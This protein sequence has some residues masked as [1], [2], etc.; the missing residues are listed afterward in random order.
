QP[1]LGRVEQRPES[2]GGSRRRASGR[3]L[4]LREPAPADKNGCEKRQWDDPS[5]FR[6]LVTVWGLEPDGT[7]LFLGKS[8]L[9]SRHTLEVANTWQQGKAGYQRAKRAG[10]CPARR[11]GRAQASFWGL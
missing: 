1:G 2:S 8:S 11:K 10:G 9:S 4:R 7:S 5:R 6:H 3:N